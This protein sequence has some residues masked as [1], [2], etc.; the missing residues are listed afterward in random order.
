MSDDVGTLV[1]R[2]LREWD[3][4]SAVERTAALLALAEALGASSP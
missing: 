2:L 1:R 3:H 4:L